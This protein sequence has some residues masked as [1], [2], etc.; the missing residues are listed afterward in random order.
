MIL[1]HVYIAIVTTIQTQC[2]MFYCLDC[3]SRQNLNDFSHAFGSGI[4]TTL[5]IKQVTLDLQTRIE[6]SNNV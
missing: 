5:V 3:E 2:R 4:K 6:V 1:E